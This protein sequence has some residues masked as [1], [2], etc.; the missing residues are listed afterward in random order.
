MKLR[1]LI[2]AALFAAVIA[3]LS[4]I[5]IP[6][7]SGVPIT[8][9]TLAIALTGAV[10]GWKRGVVSVLV[11]IAVGAV[12]VPVFS[13]F[14]AGFG[15]LIGMTG[16]F[17]FGFIPMV[18]LCGIAPTRKI[19]G[20]LFSLLGL[21]LCHVFGVVQFALLTGRGLIESALAVSVPYLIKDIVSVAAALLIAVPIR[22]GLA[23]VENRSAA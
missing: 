21:V 20:V 18:I 14:G 10:L 1:N 13:S 3:C 2:L 7:P 6:T 12:G 5:S 16:G 23:A 15:W 4:Q 19:A 9:Q 8:L 17:I 22:R 11:Y